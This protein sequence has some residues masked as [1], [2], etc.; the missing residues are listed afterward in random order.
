MDV[1]FLTNFMPYPLNSGSAVHTYVVLKA[2][3]EMGCKTDLLCFRESE[4]MESPELNDICREVVQVQQNLITAKHTGEMIW[5][6][7]RSLFSSL[8]FVAYKYRSPKMECCVQDHLERNNY[9]VVF[10][11]P[12]NLGIY[13]PLVKRFGKDKVKI[14]LI[15]HDCGYRVLESK[16]EYEKF[17]INKMIYNIEGNK[18][19]KFEKSLIEK[20]DL[21][22]FLTKD[23]HDILQGDMDY[24][25]PYTVVPT[26]IPEH[27]LKKIPENISSKTPI[28]MMFLGTL[29]WEPNNHGILWFLRN[30]MEELNQT[31]KVELY[32]IGNSPSAELKREVARFSNVV[33]TG[34][35]ESL[36]KYFDLCDVMISPIYIGSGIKTKIL[37]AYSRGFPVI[38]SRFSVI[39]I[40]YEADKSIL[41]ADTYEEYI[42][43]LRQLRNQKTYE[44]VSKRSYQIYKETYSE[45][46]IK[47]KVKNYVSKLVS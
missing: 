8:P 6:G 15:E 38:A 27:M 3:H 45:T 40:E 5:K 39:G 30:V 44:S 31:D 25:I 10:L 11:E 22:V 16:A 9:S 47:E 18:V 35:V 46:I 33:L 12:F 43:A 20:V 36:D 42:Q 23:D 26:G 1:L 21:T 34:F 13:Y 19:K 41:L 28:R 37:D 29:T 24:I 7:I 32:I 4:E 14:V 2:L 17:I